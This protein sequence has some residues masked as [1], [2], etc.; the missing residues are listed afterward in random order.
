MLCP[1]E[2]WFA[3]GRM[4]QV[5]DAVVIRKH[6]CQRIEQEFGQA[7][8]KRCS[9]SCENPVVRESAIIEVEACL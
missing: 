5:G 7:T 3:S 6:C 1:L 9:I 4:V 8:L 2:R